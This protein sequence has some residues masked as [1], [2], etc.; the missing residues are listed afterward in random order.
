MPSPLL[1]L[2]SLGLFVHSSVS[3]TCYACLSDTTGSCSR[4]KLSSA[5]TCSG[6]VCAQGYYK[7]YGMYTNTPV[8]KSK[9]FAI[10][11]TAKLV[12]IFG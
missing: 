8:V 7:E 10:P 11:F 4:S 5:S 2:L 9:L 12:I 3:V 1:L 6:E